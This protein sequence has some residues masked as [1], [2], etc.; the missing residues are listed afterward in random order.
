MKE[1][2]VLQGSA[3]TFSDVVDNPHS[4]VIRS[5]PGFYV[6]KRIYIGLFSTELFLKLKRHHFFE[7]RWTW[8]IRTVDERDGLWTYLK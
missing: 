8:A 6:T 3:M 4:H 7:S 5:F 2:F 1:V